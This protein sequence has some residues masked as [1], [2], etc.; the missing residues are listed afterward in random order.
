MCIMPLIKVVK[1]NFEDEN[2]NIELVIITCN[3][4][5]MM[6]CLG[7]FVVTCQ[8]VYGRNVELFFKFFWSI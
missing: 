8:R 2:Y 5:F 6:L 4:P 3:E 1:L 7:V